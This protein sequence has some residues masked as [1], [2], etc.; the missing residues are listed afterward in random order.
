MVHDE[1]SLVAAMNAMIIYKEHGS[2]ERANGLL[3]RAPDWVDATT[4]W[5][6]KLWRLDMLNWPPLAQDAQ[7][8]AA[9]A[10]LIVLALGCCAELPAGLLNR[11]EAWA[12]R[13]WVENAAVAVFYA[14]SSDA[15]SAT[16]T[17]KL[18]EFVRRHG[19]SLICGNADPAEDE[20]AELWADL[21]EREVAQTVTLAHILE[22]V[23]SGH[24]QHWGIS[25]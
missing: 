9:E 19:L 10:H 12:R 8:D 1:R 13:R 5:T 11:L 15:L 21:H 14:G 3:H 20:R 2:A 18:S 7:R 24:Y 16:A 23:P 4:R 25:E 6:V 22:Q 17:P